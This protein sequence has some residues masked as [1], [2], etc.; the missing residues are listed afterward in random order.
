M[1]A[2]ERGMAFDE[3]HKEFAKGTPFR[4]IMPLAQIADVAVLLANDL[5]A[6][7]TATMANATGG[8]RIA[9]T[10]DRTNRCLVSPISA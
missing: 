10:G 9:R 7:M 4:P 6:A 1:A 2:R 8:E 5:A 3:I